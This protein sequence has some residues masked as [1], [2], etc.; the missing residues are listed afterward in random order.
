MVKSVEAFT[1]AAA[2]RTREAQGIQVG[3]YEL[4]KQMSAES[5]LDVLVDPDNL[6]QSSVTIPEGLRVEDTIEL[7]AKKTDIPLAAVR[8]GRS[9][10]PEAIGL[11]A[12]AKGNAEG[13]LFPATYA[14]PPNA[15]ADVDAVGDGR[16]V[17]AGRR[18]G[19]PRGA[20]EGA[21]LHARAS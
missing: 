18:R 7:L 21:R 20:R 9:S 4:R 17:A 15:D 11:P 6:V 10:D 3:F 8:A 1:E 14:F 5:A 12:Y 16:P 13:Y 19:R 2:E